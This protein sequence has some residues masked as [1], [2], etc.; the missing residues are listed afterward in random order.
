MRLRSLAPSTERSGDVGRPDALI[1]GPLHREIDRLFDEFSRGLAPLQRNAANLLPNIDVAETDKKI[2]V[3]VEMPGLER[4][5]VDISLEDNVL[6]IR[7]EKKVEADRD[8][9]NVFDRER[10]YGVL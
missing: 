5:N 4:G 2:D 8:D 6:T 7:G 9:I 3:S 1:F 10:A